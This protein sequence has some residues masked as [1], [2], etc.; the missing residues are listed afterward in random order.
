MARDLQMINDELV[1]FFLNSCKEFISE[2]GTV[3]YF[4]A[5]GDLNHL[6]NVTKKQAEDSGQNPMAVL[7]RTDGAKEMMLKVRGLQN[8]LG[9]Y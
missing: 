2:Q 7:L 1:K 6:I 8:S 9:L 5:M 3:E 4:R